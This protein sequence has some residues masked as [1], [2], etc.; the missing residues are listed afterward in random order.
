MLIGYET[1]HFVDSCW[2]R[3][4]ICTMFRSTSSL[5][6]KKYAVSLAE[7]RVCSSIISSRTARVASCQHT[8]SLTSSFSSVTRILRSSATTNG[9]G[10]MAY[11]SPLQDFFDLMRNNGPTALG[12]R[13]DEELLD[14][15][16]QRNARCL[17]C[18][19]PESA[20][21]F[22][23]TSYGRIMMA[24]YVHPNEHRVVMT[25]QARYLPLDEH[26]LEDAAS[27]EQVESL[28]RKILREMVG[29][30]Y[31]AK[32][33]TLRLSSNQF[34]SRIENKR[35]LVSML[36][37]LVESCQRLAKQVVEEEQ[38]LTQGSG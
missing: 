14:L 18:G 24:P 2:P 17:P 33:G 28:E 16:A 38:K 22:T 1:S 29:T 3:L 25:V 9:S 19:I 26:F 15:Q 5:S 7:R 34:G 21:R 37:R 12:T 35:H 27:E 4:H 30:R 32:K 6:L 31:D 8:K 10:E 20:L 36:E 11:E 23:T 13:S